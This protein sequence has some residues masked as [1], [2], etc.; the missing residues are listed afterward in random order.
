M[1]G[2]LK[3]V[4]FPNYVVEFVPGEKGWTLEFQCWEELGKV[5]YI[6]VNFYAR[7]TTDAA[8]DD[9]MAAAKKSG[10]GFYFHGGDTGFNFRKVD[11]TNCTNEPPSPPSMH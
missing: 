11:H 10:I 6:G 9:M 8:Y 5:R 1:G 3:N 7:N 4:I 2:L